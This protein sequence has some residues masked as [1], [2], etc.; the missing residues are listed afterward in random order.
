MFVKEDKEAGRNRN[1]ARKLDGASDWSRIERVRHGAETE[2]TRKRTA[3]KEKQAHPHSNSVAHLF[4]RGESAPRGA[5]RQK[6]SGW[7]T[8]PERIG[9]PGTDEQGGEVT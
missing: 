7:T 8:K 3:A 4:Q 6:I 2:R 5:V 1:S 9:R